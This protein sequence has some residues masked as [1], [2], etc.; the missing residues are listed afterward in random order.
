MNEPCVYDGDHLLASA[1]RFLIDGQEEDAAN[2]LLSC[3]LDV[4]E[5]GE[6][7]YQGDE[8]LCAVHVE[9]T[10]PRAA[11]DILNNRDHP[12]TKAVLRALEAVLPTHTYIKHFSVAAE[13][14]SLDPRWREELLEI[15]RGK[16]VHNQVIEAK[17]PRIWNNLRFRSES[18]VRVARALDQANVMFLP[19]CRA[20]IGLQ[21]N[22]QNR[23]ADFLVCHNGKLGI[24]EVD[25]EPFHPP[26]RTAEDH[27]R[28]RLF[29][30]HGI[31]VVEHFDAGECFENPAGVVARFLNILKK[32]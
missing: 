31:L 19:N 23:E 26:S 25:G 13:L 22:R 32:T 15:A 2:V 8:R 5:S 29:K 9:H 12:I 7:W 20:R 28:D 21:A 6:T 24:L 17:A 27:E 30:L 1:A 10:G 11:Y 3:S 18:E 4:W 14:I 16:G